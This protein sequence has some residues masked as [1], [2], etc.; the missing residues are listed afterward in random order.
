MWDESAVY[1]FSTCWCVI[2]SDLQDA[3][4]SL[5]HFQYSAIYSLFEAGSQ[6]SSLCQGHKAERQQHTCFMKA[7]CSS[8][9][10][11]FCCCKAASACTTAGQLSKPSEAC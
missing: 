9:L 5:A 2:V 8:Y 6:L 4:L 7:A 3:S 1:I 10:A 11:D